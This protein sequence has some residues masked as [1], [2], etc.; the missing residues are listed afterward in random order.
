MPRT[1]IASPPRSVTL[2]SAVPFARSVL[3]GHSSVAAMAAVTVPTVLM[4]ALS[5]LLLQIVFH[6]SDAFPAEYKERVSEHSGDQHHGDHAQRPSVGVET[7]LR[8]HVD[9]IVTRQVG[10]G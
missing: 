3:I 1:G 6:E 5:A 2:R 8:S 7:V 4:Q 10:R 9:G